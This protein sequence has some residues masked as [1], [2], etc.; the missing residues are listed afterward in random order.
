MLGRSPASTSGSITS[1]VAASRPITVSFEASTGAKCTNGPE[2]REM[3]RLLLPFRLLADQLR[4]RGVRGTWRRLV[5]MVKSRSAQRKRSEADRVYDEQAGVDTAAWVRVPDL[6]TESPNRHYV[7]G[8]SRRT[9]RSSI[10]D[11]QA[12][13]RPQRVHLRRLRPGQGRVLMLAAEYPF[14]R[15]VGVEFSESLDRTARQNLTKLG[16][17]PRG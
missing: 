11:G 8:T 14:K 7:S 1:K 5:R 2:C 17:T 4:R 9:S 3:R 16:G 6:D 12:R 10:A 15:I 13:R